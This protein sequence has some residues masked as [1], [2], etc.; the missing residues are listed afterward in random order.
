LSSIEA[1]QETIPY[2]SR[3][4]QICFPS[5]T[6]NV[7]RCVRQ[8]Y[9]PIWWFVI[10]F[11]SKRRPKIWRSIAQFQWLLWPKRAPNAEQLSSN[12][13]KTGAVWSCW[14]LYCGRLLR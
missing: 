6:H 9:P 13:Q 4:L 3:I 11:P 10:M 1:W 8:Y 14:C 5:L 12:Q 7:S 2:N